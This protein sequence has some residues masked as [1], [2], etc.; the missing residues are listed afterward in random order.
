VSPPVGFQKSFARRDE[1]PPPLERDLSVKPIAFYLPQFHPIE[2]NN[3]NWGQG[4]TEWNNVVRGAPEFDGHHQPRVPADLGFYDLRLPDVQVQQA[5]HAANAGIAAFCYYY[6]WFDGEQPMRLPL[7]NHLNNDDIS[8]KFCLSFANEN[9]TKTWDGLDSEVI[10][11]QSYGEKFEERFWSDIVPFLKSEK[12]LLDSRGQPI[13][14]IYKP[15]IIPNFKQV[16]DNLRRLALKAGFPGLHLVGNMASSLGAVGLDALH[17]FAPLAH[18][19]CAER[20]LGGSIPKIEVRGRVP[21][22]GSTVYDYRQFL[23]R[24]RMAIGA[25]EHVYPAVMPSWDNTARRPLR[26]SV[27]ADTNPDLFCRWVDLAARR[28]SGTTEKLLFINA[29]NEWAEGAYLEPDQHFGWGYLDALRRGLLAAEEKRPQADPICIF[30]HV[31]YADLWS[32]I[33]AQLA[34]EI[35]EPFNLVLTTPLDEPFAPPASDLLQGFEILRYENKGRDILPFLRALRDTRFR[36]EIG[37]K[38]HTKKSL[39]REDGEKWR[40]FLLAALVRDGASGS[41]T[42]LLRSDPNLGFVAPEGHWAPLAEHIGSNHETILRL[43]ELC[44]VDAGERDIETGRFIAGSM[45][46]FRR[47]AL[48]AIDFDA[49][50]ELFHEERG[51]TDGT[52]AHAM[53]RLFALLG[54]K[55]GYVTAATDQVAAL[56][57]QTGS[58]YWIGTRLL[59]FSDQLSPSQFTEKIALRTAPAQPPSASAVHHSTMEQAIERLAYQHRFMVDLYRKLPMGWRIFMRRA[60]GRPIA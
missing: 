30:V 10:L 43:M 55:R 15:S 12:Y 36:F 24:E 57:A 7:E 53:E 48:D 1:P 52:P 37:L 13:L 25:H 19:T 51:E 54:E 8:L 35:K 50:V 29:W 38:L 14:L 18:G 31:Y 49:V 47:Q 11:R 34:S 33:A 27:M 39:H 9:W 46:W 5:R 21:A 22:S 60:M 3:R 17:E 32:E 44:R 6:Y 58:S 28:A 45:F 56:L 16:A 2:V 59:L 20:E 26:G 23:M 4:F 41:I 40:R 42:K